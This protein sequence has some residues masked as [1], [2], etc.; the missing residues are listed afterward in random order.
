MISLQNFQRVPNL[1]ILK[2]WTKYAK[3]GFAMK[4]Y[5]NVGPHDKNA[6]VGSRYKVL[7]KLYSSLAAS[8]ALTD[9]SFLISLDAYESTLN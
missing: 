8:A 1:Y 4:N 6:D 7:L 5:M 3:D 9:E 2:R